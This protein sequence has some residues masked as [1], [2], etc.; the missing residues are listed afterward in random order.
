MFM[1]KK[2]LLVEDEPTINRMIYNYLTNEDYE[3][4]H[5]FDGKAALDAIQKQSFHL[6]CLDIMLP[7]MSGWEIAKKL[8]TQSDVP[9]IMMSALSDEEDILKGYDL[10]VDD[11]ITKPFNPR[12]LVAKINALMARFSHEKTVPSHHIQVPHL[13][14][15]TRRK[16]IQLDDQELPLARKEYELL[17]FFIENSNQICSREHVF[18]R[19]WGKDV[20]GDPR[21]VDTYVKKLRKHLNEY[22]DFIKTIFGVGYRF[23]AYD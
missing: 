15:D 2:I 16:V 6:V 21:L 10:K 4:T 1:K 5:A 18:D 8:R 14:V 22:G 17:T 13:Q 7:K 11:Y 3:V 20:E 12:V 19:V 9:I 23:E